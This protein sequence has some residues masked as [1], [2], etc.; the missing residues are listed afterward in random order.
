VF[1]MIA[2]ANL[3]DRMQMRTEAAHEVFTGP[4]SSREDCVTPAAEDGVRADTGR[5]A[6]TRFTRTAIAAAFLASGAASAAPVQV[7]VT[8]YNLAHASRV[9]FAATHMGFHGGVF[10]AFDIGQEATPEIVSAAERCNGIEWLAAFAVAD[11]GATI[12]TIA[13]QLRPLVSRSMTF[14]VDQ[15][16]N[17]HFTFASMV[18][19]NNDFFIGDD[20]P[21]RYQLFDGEG[22]LQITSITQRSRDIWDAGSEIFD[23]LAAAFVGTGGLRANQNSVVAFNFAELAAFDGLTTAAGYVFDSQLAADTEIYRIGFEV[24]PIPEPENYV[25]MALGLAVV[26]WAGKR[27]SRGVR[28]ARGARFDGHAPHIRM[29]MGSTDGLQLD[30]VCRSAANRAACGRRGR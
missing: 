20:G 12:G 13:G 22:N 1:R 26:G 23:P 11:S 27:K 6:L 8:I 3:C 24:A 15:W 17:R 30:T 19:P 18:N 2:T 28:G 16:A 14:S 29:N 7:T 10:G 21:Q 4:C 9:A 5:R 25:V